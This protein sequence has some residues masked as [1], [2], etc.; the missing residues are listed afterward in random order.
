VASLVAVALTALV[1][2]LGV[3]HLRSSSLGSSFGVGIGGE[4]AALAGQDAKT[5]ELFTDNENLRLWG[6]GLN[7][8][9][10]LWPEMFS[11]EKMV[12]GGCDGRFQ[13][14]IAV[15][16]N[17]I[18]KDRPAAE[19]D[20]VNV[21]SLAFP[22]TSG[23][24][25][26]RDNR[27]LYLVS[28]PESGTGKAMGSTMWKGRTYSLQKIT[29]HS[30]AEHMVN[31]VLGEL[32]FQLEH[33]DGESGKRLNIA[34][35]YLANA[36]SEFL[37]NMKINSHLNFANLPEFAGDKLHLHDDFSAAS[38]FPGGNYLNGEKP[39][40]TDLSF[41]HYQG[42]LTEPPCTEG[43]DWIVIEQ[44]GWVH[45]S[46]LK[47]GFPKSLIGNARPDQKLWNRPVYHSSSKQLNG[48]GFTYNLED[49]D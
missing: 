41:F 49:R 43:V 42:S 6:Y 1:A 13:S 35:T 48:E 39:V 30:P 20:D 31:G 32:E 5:Q 7:N 15:Q 14:P 22:V 17:F 11:R 46:D 47:V 44:T 21:L 16:R 2:V 3:V 33:I 25:W 38:L 23:W 8:G 12:V 19:D 4:Q 34:I 10:N 26:V 40:Y 28:R 37:H 9:P 27:Q 29:V 36:P 24:L 18:S 45:P